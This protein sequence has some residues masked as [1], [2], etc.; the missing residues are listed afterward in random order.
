[1]RR[2]YRR[3]AWILTA[4]LLLNLL[5]PGAAFASDNEAVPTFEVGTAQGKPGDTVEIPIFVK[6]NPGVSSIKLSVSYDKDKLGLSN[7]MVNIQQG[8]ITNSPNWDA[9]PYILNW[10][11]GT[12]NYTV[13]EFTFATL[14]FSILENTTP[15]YANIKI[16]YD[17]DDIYNVSY[18]TIIFT[19]QNGGITIPHTSVTAMVDAPAKGIELDTTVDV[20]TATG[21]TGTVE[22]YEGTAAAG[23]AVTG[24]AKANQVYTAKITLTAGEKEVFDSSLNSTTTGDGYQI[25]GVSDT[26]LTLTKTFPATLAKELQ[27]LEVITQ[28]STTTYTH[29]DPFNSAGMVV[30]ATYDDNT[31]DEDFTGYTVEY[32]T[33]GKGYLKK[34]DTAVTLKA[35][36]QSVAVN[37]LTVNAKP[38]TIS[39][40]TAIDRVYDGTTAVTLHGGTLTGVI[41]GETV[42]AVTPTSGTITDA[43]VGSGKIVTIS[44]I[45][46]T[47]AD[48]G[49]YTLTQP[50]VT[51]NISAKPLTDSMITLGTQKTYTGTEQDVVI[52]SVT[53]GSN[54]L[55]ENTDYTIASGNKATNVENTTLTISGKGNYS[56]TASVVWS[57]QKATPTSNDF[58][59]TVPDGEGVAYTGSPISITA[60]T[61]NKAGMGAVTVKYGADTTAPTNVGSY[62]VTFDVADGTNYTSASGLSIGTLKINKAEYAGPKTKDV[63][64]RSNLEASNKTLTLPD[65]PTGASYGT[66]SVTTSNGLLNGTP[67]VSGT[68]LTY[69]VNSKSAETVEKITIAVTGATNYKDYNVEVTFTAKDKD[70]AGVTVTPASATVKYGE[71]VTIIASKTHSGAGTWSWTYPEDF[72]EAVGATDASSITLKAKKADAD[73]KIISAKF[74]NETHIGTGA[75]T[76][77]VNKAASAVTKAPAGKAGLAYTGSAQD[78]V[79]AGT[80]DGGDL[81]Y[82]VDGGAFANTVPTGMNAKSYTVKYKVIGDSNHE[83]SAEQTL[84]VVIAKAD[85]DIGAVSKNSPDTIY[86][87]TE[88][89][90]IT[91]AKTNSIAGTLLLDEGQTLTVGTKAYG[92]T[93]TPA[94]ASNY[95]VKTGTIS[96]TVVE[97]ELVSIAVTTNPTKT[98][99][100][101]AETLDTTGAVITATYDSSATKV[102]TDKTVFT[103]TAL[104]TV[105]T[106]VIT[107]T[108]GDKTVNFNVIVEKADA[109]ILVDVPV[110]LKNSVTTEQTVVLGTAGMPSDAG[111]LRYAK[112]T[113][114]TTGS[115]TV[116]S[117]SVDASTGEVRYMLSGGA[118]EDTVT[119]P[120]IITSDNYANSTVKIKIT[121][122][123]KNIP[124][125]TVPNITCTYTGEPVPN[126]AITGAATFDGKTV[127]GTWSWEET[128]ART[129]VADSG[130]KTVVF[131]PTDTTAYSAVKANITLTINKAIPTGAPAFTQITTDG[132]TLADADLR[133]GSIT[134]T[135]GT[136]VWNDGDS[137]PV[138]ANT[139]YSWTYTPADTDNYSLLTGSITPYQRSSGGDGGDGGSII[140]NIPDIPFTPNTS[141]SGGSSSSST[142]TTTTR[143]PDGS[144]TTRTENKSTGTVTETTRNADGSSTTVEIKSDGTTSTEE[145]DAAGNKVATVVN[146]DGSSVT[147][148]SKTDGTTAAVITDTNGRV[149]AVVTLPATVVSQ[150]QMEEM[151]ITLPIPEVNVTKNTETASVVT[152]QTGSLEP[153]KVEIP[154]ANT[155][156]GT[157]AVLVRADGTEEVVKTSMSTDNGVTAALPDGAT[158]KIVDNSKTFADVPASHWAADAVSFNSARELFSGTSETA[159]SPEK[160]VTR[161]MLMTILARF[162]GTDTSGGS[163]WYEKAVEWAI[164]NGISDGS[165]PNS[166]ITREQLAAILY[167]YAQK[168]G[169]DTGLDENLNLYS[170]KDVSSISSWAKDAMLWCIQEGLINGKG[171]GTLDPHGQATRAEAAVILQRFCEMQ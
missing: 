9:Y 163:I 88:L 34:G 5:L 134:P 152:I 41:S 125:V 130:V 29:G 144:T 106:Q 164:A 131:A 26:E 151:P 110:S 158:V 126:S 137:K 40:L 140:P 76:V 96:L 120:V 86:P 57:L 157:V 136:I 52:T 1:M 63:T 161:A 100:K 132:K 89:N 155:T 135:G 97:D 72:F 107:A 28:P 112:G 7:A 119:L 21:Y 117:W 53:D 68:E 67:T 23:T 168:Q 3:L 105:G 77:T 70:D 127:E 82:N 8:T 37:N 44:N 128:S 6:N 147:N 85:P 15:G 19:A 80:A 32:N 61:T 116:T 98:T 156:P 38:L 65:P 138:E 69:S 104:M 124:A 24:N 118:A 36:T 33:A 99:Y 167:R 64:V 14:T 146:P 48:A 153:V 165:N 31:T 55:P 39:G 166:N 114:E 59:F 154:A 123:D 42:S 87:H 11:A 162:D 102:L 101:Y 2:N 159:F 66:V 78:L 81:Q 141:G 58:S 95:N 4:V 142:T 122:T 74:E 111:A 73:A 47:G 115:A 17:P 56:G 12:S 90:T 148:V 49:N 84:T 25:T 170:W 103:P 150:A 13:S 20:G 171:A 133:I 71:N 18:E 145:I 62:T 169:K 83:D 149:N 79:N 108:Y 143:N 43:N 92:W 10:V 60:P 129:N 93:F 16:E 46:L 121:L 50:A 54:T 35:G 160:P 22:W 75:A 27:T 109:K 94:D 139:A 51:V 91:L 45:D 113:E 30:R